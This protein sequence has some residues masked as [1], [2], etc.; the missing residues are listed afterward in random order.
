[1]CSILL[2]L[3][4]LASAWTPLEPLGSSRISGLA[5]SHD[6][7]IACGVGGCV[8]STDGGATWKSPIQPLDQVALGPSG[9]SRGILT[10]I[11]RGRAVRSSDLG[12]TWTAW[13]TGVAGAHV[14]EAIA[15]QG[16]FAF[17]S[18]ISD[19]GYHWY[20]RTDSTPWKQL[21]SLP[22][23]I[24]TSTVTGI[25]VNWKG[26]L[27]RTIP[28]DT[29]GTTQP[30][31]QI[32][33][34]GG[35]TWDSV[36]SHSMLRQYA[37]G[38]LRI[39]STPA[40][41]PTL[42][43][44]DSGRTWDTTTA[45]GEFIDGWIQDPRDSS[46]GYPG[47]SGA[48]TIRLD[49]LG[50]LLSW[51]RSGRT[52]WAAGWNGFFASQDSGANWSRVTTPN[53][54]NVTEIRWH[55]SSLYAVHEGFGDRHVARHLGLAGWIRSIAEIS[56]AGRT[57]L[58]VCA[59]SLLVVGYPYTYRLAN[60]RL[61]SLNAPIGIPAAVEDLSCIPGRTL[62]L[63]Q[64]GHT[65][66]TW[67]QS[68]DGIGMWHAHAVTSPEFLYGRML[69]TTPAGAYVVARKDATSSKEDL[70]YT[71]DAD[72]STSILLDST[73]DFASVN[74]SSRGAWISTARG[75]YLCTDEPRCRRI[76]L[77]GA[78]S[79][80]A[81]QR[82]S[83]QG[84]FVFVAGAPYTSDSLSDTPRSR[85]FASSD[86]GKTW[87]SF[88]AP[89]LAN[90]AAATPSGIVA[91]FPGAGLWRLDS[92]LFRVVGVDSRAARAATPTLRADGR[93]LTLTGIVSGAGLRV[94]DMSGRVLLELHPDVLDGR[95]Q[96]V[97]P[98]TAQGVLVATL[99]AAGARSSF[100][101]VAT[102]R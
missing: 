73:H 88:A 66:S 99:D 30:S 97:L 24:R 34:D 81:F 54:D 29:F 64:Y 13:N 18:A 102:A 55:E 101:V 16:N 21:D 76:E 26:D 70:F 43:S 86:S 75:L 57:V 44:I 68:S 98:A 77:P 39:I 22:S 61:T 46:W 9:L 84:A 63:D 69:A 27:L 89:G 45:T 95:A 94:L 80:W 12:S 87:T 19:S 25:A 65:F 49:S 51:V 47:I 36:N 32:S 28:I 2:G 60:D 23:A 74:G 37:P 11:H 35:L 1:M 14:L 79:L 17:A 33:R 6:T 96:V 3:S 31:T 78:D 40:V 71:P 50:S 7:V 38:I 4:L 93:I 8:H 59:D 83:V 15:V 5:S 58:D 20:T 92:D 90:S 56:Q 82:A 72:S 10:A 91:S 52:L 53:L 41:G 42:L 48:R 85:L 67:K 100:R 62:G